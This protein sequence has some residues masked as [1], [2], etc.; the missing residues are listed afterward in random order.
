MKRLFVGLICS[1]LICGAAAANPSI[2][3]PTGLVTMPT[4]DT[5]EFGEAEG[6]FHYVDYDEGS[7]KIFGANAGVGMG[8]ELGLASAHNGDSETFVN[9]KW[10][11]VKETSMSPGI[12]I[13]AID[14]T[15]SM[16]DMEP[17][18]VL[19]KKLSVPESNISFSG[20]VGYV[21]GDTDELMLGASVN[22][23]PQLQIMADYIDDFAIG[24]LYAVTEEFELGMSALDGDLMLSASYKF[25]FN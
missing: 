16:G 25:A 24:A 22:V 19:S 11:F 17:Y 12:A 1:A 6:F 8:I 7:G 5:L 9:A 10:N 13:G 20:H 21:A 4:A 15:G 23:T 2:Y 18:I 14:L 3:G